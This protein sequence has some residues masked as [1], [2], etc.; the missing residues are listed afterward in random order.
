MGTQ[1]PLRVAVSGASGMVGAALVRRLEADGDSV[2]RM[3]RRPARGPD[4]LQWDPQ[5]GVLDP[6]SLA[7]IDAV[8]NLAGE[9]IGERWTEERL[10]RMRDSR[11]QGTRLIA[12]TLA[13]MSEGP[14][15]LVNASAVGLYGDRGDETVD[16]R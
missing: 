5:R 10:R 15:V 8:V 2:V 7:G 9:N 3:V 13:G 1:T 11:I 16:E 6:A 12:T 4:E 14:R